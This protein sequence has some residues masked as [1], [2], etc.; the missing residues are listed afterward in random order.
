[1]SYAM[2]LALLFRAS[3]PR[4]L[5][6]LDSVHCCSVS[7]Q[8]VISLLNPTKRRMSNSVAGKKMVVCQP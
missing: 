7:D 4:I 5:L 1:M 2:I 3:L 8:E 6:W